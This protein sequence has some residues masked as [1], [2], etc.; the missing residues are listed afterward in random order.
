MLAPSNRPL[1]F[2]YRTMSA[3]WRQR[4][5]VRDQRSGVSTDLRPLT[6]D[7]CGPAG[8]ARLSTLVALCALLLVV[9]ALPPALRSSA[10]ADSSP[11]TH[12]SSLGWLSDHVWLHSPTL[13]SSPSALSAL[14]FT[15]LRAAEPVAVVIPLTGGGSITSFGSALTENFDG[16]SST[17]ATGVAWTD[18]STISG[19]YASQ[20]AYNVSTGSSTTGA[21]YS[22]GVAGTNA[23]TDRALGALASGGTGT[24]YYGFRLTNATG[25]SVGGLSISYK[26]EQWRNSAAAAQTTNFQYQ[27]ANAG[28]ITAINTPTTGWTTF[29]PLSFT[30]P[31]TGGSAGLLDGNAAA[32]RTAKSATLTFGTPVANGQEIWIRWQ[33]NDDTGNDHGLGIDDLS[34]TA[35]AAAEPTT[36]ATNVVFSNIT[37]TSMTVGWTNGNGANRI[38]LAKEGSAVNSDPVDGTTYTANAAFGGGTQIG[39]GNYVIFAGSGNSVDVTGLTGGKTYYFAV[40]EFNGSS[41]GENYLTTSPATGNQTTDLVF[42]GDGNLPAGTYRNVTLNCTTFTNVTLTGDVTITGTFTLNNCSNLY[43]NNHVLSGAGSFVMN[44]GTWLH[45]S[46]ANGITSGT[47]LSGN[48]QVTGG[49]TFPTTGNYDYD[50]GTNQVVGDGLPSPVNDLLISKNGGANN[51]A[52]TGNS[53]QV[54]TTLLEI[55]Q[56]VYS[57]HSTYTDV[58]IDSGGTLTLAG[59]S[60]VSGNWTNNG[61][62]NN[63]GFKITFNGAANQLISGSTSTA[64]ATLAISNTGV[65]GSNTVSLAQNISDT[66]LNITSGVFDQGASFNVAS[67]TV[68]VSAGATWNDV[69]SGGVALSGNVANA[70]TI[71][72]NG[73]TTACG[74]ADSIAITSTGGQRAWTGTGT[75]NMTDVTVSNQGATPPPLITVH[76]GTDAGSNGLNWVFLGCTANSYTWTGASGPA[77]TDWTVPTNWSP[78][79]ATPDPG[80]VLTFDNN[81]SP[82]VTNIPTQTISRLRIIG[83]TSPQF[84]AGANGNILTIN[85]GA[86]V[87]GFDVFGLSVTGSNAL[88]IKLGSGTLGTVTNFM[89]V[90]GGAHKVISNDAGGI[91]FPNNSI[92]STQAG[93]SDFPFGD[94]DPGSGAAGSVI[95]QSGATYIHNA[96]SSPFGGNTASV[97]TFQTGS[98]AQ[99]LTG[100][101]FDACGRTYADLLIGSNSVAVTASQTGSCASQN[102]QFDNLTVNN[103]AGD[104]SLSYTGTGTIT[105]RGNISSTGAGTGLADVTLTPGA[106]GILI[107]GGGTQTFSHTNTK[108]LN[109]DGN[110]NIAS[111]TTLT[112][113]RILVLGMINSNSKTVTVASGATLNAG[114][115]GYVVGSLRR[116]FTGAGSKAFEVGALNGYSPVDMTAAAGGTFPAVFTVNSS[117]AK[118]PHIH[119][120][121]GNALKRYW[122]L[123]EDSGSITADLV[124]HYLDPAD[125]PTNISPAFTDA[126][127]I[128]F[129]YDGSFS[130]PSAT[131]NTAANTAT[132]T[133]VS[134]FS[135][136]T[137]ADPSAVTPGTLTF[138]GAP[139]ST[140]EGNSSSHDVT[141][142]VSRT[143]GTDGA[144]DVSYTTSDGTAQLAD[145]DYVLASGVLHWND[146]ETGN[147]SFTITVNGD[148]T[149][150]ADE[151]VN[152]TLSPPTDLATITPPNPTTLTILNDDAPPASLVVNTTDDNDFGACF[153]SPGHC[154]LREA[155]NAANF[156]V[157]TST[158]TFAAAANGTITLT[159]ALPNLAN[160]LTINGNGAANTVISGNDLF[161]PFTVSSSADV[162]ITGVTVTHGKGTSGGAI[163]NDGTLTVTNSILSSNMVTVGDGGGIFNDIGATLTVTNCTISGNSAGSGGGGIDNDG[164]LM[165]MGSTISGN[166]ADNGGGLR[167]VGP[168]FVTNCTI[169]GN[170]AF[171]NGGGIHNFG[172]T[173]R[174]TNST[175]TNNFADSADNGGLGGGIFNESGVTV[176]LRNTI[177]ARNFNGASPG[178]N[179]DDLNGD[180]VDTANCFNNL[181][182]TGG[183]GGLTNTNGNQ[184]DVADPMLGPLQNN[185]GLTFTHA[186]LSGSTAIDAGD[187]CVADATHCSDPNIT[188]LTTDQ[189]GAGFPR[190]VDGDLNGTAAVDIGAYEFNQTQTGATFVVNSTN[191]PGDGVCD[192]AECTLREAI[193]AAN[194]NADANIIT[195]DIPATDLGHYY[196][197]DDGSGTPNGHV[198]PANVTTTTASVD[199]SIPDIDPDW[200][201]SWWSIRPTTTALP[202]I[203]QQVTINGYSQPGASPNTQ[204]ATDD[205]VI[206]IELNGVNAGANAHGLAANSVSTLQGL[207]INHF[208]G[209]GIGLLLGSSSGG[210]STVSGNFIGTDVSGTL[211]AANGLAGLFITH[212]TGQQVGCTV[213]E[214][215]NII[216]GN[217]GEGVSILTAG[218]NFVQGNFIGVAANGTS[219]L[220]N[221]G[222]GIEIYTGGSNNTIGAITNVLGTQQ[223]RPE[224]GGAS[225]CQRSRTGSPASR[226]NSKPNMVARVAPTQALS[227]ANVIAGNGEDGV[228]VSSAGDTGNLI[229]QN[230]IFS[231]GSGPNGGLGI[232]LVGPSDPPNGVTL[233]D[234]QGH[235]GPNNL[236]NFPVITIATVGTTTVS[237]TLVSNPTRSFTIEIFVNSSC[238]T[239]SGYGEGQ[240]YF[241]SAATSE[242]A[243]GQYTWQA[244]VPMMIT[245][246][247]VFT[248]TATDLT[249]N[250]T[251]EFSQCRTS[252]SNTNPTIAALPVSQ[253]EGS[254]ASSNVHIADVNDVESGPGGVTVTVNGAPS[255]TV[256]GVTVSGITNTGGTVTATVVAACGGTNATFTLTA[257]DG[258][259]GTATAMLNVTVSANTAPTLTYAP[260]YTVTQGNSLSPATGPSDNGSVASIVVQSAGMFTGKL[261]V[262]PV[263]AVVSVSNTAPAGTDNVTIRATDNCGTFTDATFA[264]T[265]NAASCTAPPSGMVAWWPGDGN[266]DD[267]TGNGNNGTLEGN[268]T[269]G[270]GK[271]EQAFDLNGTTGT[272]V[273]FTAN[274]IPVGSGPR[275]V[276]MWVK[277]RNAA[278]D[279]E[280]L[281]YGTGATRRAFGIDVDDTDGNGNVGLQLFTFGDDIQLNSGVPLNQWM[282]IAATYDGNLTINV[283]VNGELKATLPLGAPL[284]TASSNV[285]LGHFSP[286]GYF[287]GL[288]DEV[289]VFNRE[290]SQTEIRAIYNASF[291]GKCRTCTTAPPNMVSWYSAENNANDIFGTNNGTMYGGVS[292]VP[293]KLGQAFSF[294]GVSGTR[295][296]ILRQVQDD[297]TI[298]FWLNSTQN[299]FDGSNQWHSAAGLVDGEVPGVVNDFGVS[300]G[301]GKVLFGVGNVNGNDLTIRSGFVADGT[302]HHI[303][304]TRVKSS[305]A[306]ALYIDGVQVA[307]DTGG[308]QSL[309]DPTYLR[310][311]GVPSTTHFFAG[312]LDEVEIFNRA[313]SQTEIAA[314]ADAGSAGKCHT[315]TIQFSS[316]TYQVTEGSGNATITVTRAGTHDTLAHVNYATS[317]GTATAGVDYTETSSTLDFAVGEVSKTFDVP[318]LQ[319]NSFAHDQTVNLT[320]S[321]V[322]GT[323]AS[324]GTPNP[325]LLTIHDTDDQAP[326]FSITQSV[327]HNEGNTGTTDF[328]FTVT[329]TGTTQVPATVDFATAAGLTNPATG[330]VSCGAGID[331]QSQNNTLN[332]AANQTTQTITVKVCGD[333]TYEANEKFTVV[334]SNPTEATVSPTLGTGTGTIVNDDAAPTLSINNLAL[335]EGNSGPTDFAFTVTK[336]GNAT[337]LPTTV[338]FATV[339]GL[340][341]GSNTGATGGVSCGAGID[342]ESQSGMLTFQPNDTTMTI[343]V[344]VCGDP[345]YENN[346]LFFVNLSGPVDGS[347]I[348]N[349]GTGTIKNDDPIPTISIDNVT[350]NEGD[351]GTTDFVFHITKTNPTELPI[352]VHAKTI[353]H[354]SGQ[355]SAPSDFTAIADQ[356]FTFPASSTT[357]TQTLTV[358]VNGDT[359]Y[360]HD[361]LFFVNVFN[362]TNASVIESNGTGTIVN[363]D[364]KPTLSITSAVMHPEGNGPGTTD[365]TFTITKT[366]STEVNAT[367][368]VDTADGT[369]TAPSDYTA[370]TNQTVTFLPGETTKQVTVLVKADTRPEGDETFLV[371][372][373]NPVDCAITAGQGQGTGTIQNDD[374]CPTVFTVNNNGD[375]DDVDPGDGLCATSGGQ[376]TLRAA[377]EEAN[378][379]TACGTIDINFSIGSATITL[380]NGQLTV[381]H[382]VNVN[383][384]TLSSIV[385]SGNNA[386]RALWVNPGKTVTISNL[387]LSGGNGSGSS[388]GAILNNGGTITLTNSTVSGN[389]VSSG[390][391][392]GGIE[393]SGTLTLTN[394][395]VSGNTAPY[396]GGGIDNG[397]ASSVALTNSTVTGNTAQYGG[398]IANGGTVS[399][400]NTIIAGNS[401]SVSGPDISGSF[402]S[403]GNNLIGKSDGGSG[404]LNGSNGDQV[405]TIASPIDPLLGA[406]MNNGGPTF[407]HGLLYNSPAVDAGNDCVFTVTHCSDANIPQL[408]LDQRGL[409]RQANGD[410]IAGAHVDIGAYERQASESRPVPS[411]SNVH[412][413]LNDVRL[414]F[415]TVSGTRRDDGAAN[416]LQPAT[417]NNAV[418]ITVIPVPGDAPPTSFAAFDVTPTSAFYATPVDVCFYLPSITPKATFDKLKV[419]HRESGV[420]TDHGTYVN[421]A[422][423]IACTEVTSFSDF[424][425]GYGAVPSVA[426]GTIDGMITDSSGAPLAGTTINLSGTQA[427]EAI[428]DSS[429]NYSFEGV[430]TN[431]FYSVTPSRANY[432]FNPANRSFSALGVH[433][434]ASFTA[435]PN[436]DHANAIDTTEFF[437]RQQY[438]DFLGREPDPPGFNGWVNTIRDCAPGDT[439]CDRIHVSEA[440]FRSAEFQERGYFVYRFYASAFGR[441]PDYGEFTPDLRRVSGFLTNDQLEAAKTAF[442]NDFMARSAFAAQ[443]NSLSN[444]AYVDALINTAAVNLS[445]RPALLDGLNS[446]TLTRAQVLRQITESGEVYQK[447][448]NQAFVVMEYFGYLR[449]DPD[450]LY[451]NWIQVLDANAADSR[452]MVNGFVNSTEY[453]NR[454]AQ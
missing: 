329:K 394:S 150:E 224:G 367:V 282:H 345:N 232:N 432:T 5:E 254:L 139:Y 428:T 125:I 230:S 27:V 178:I 368:Q 420:L 407:T 446:G 44:A 104:S 299:A 396:A 88:I 374:P 151:T 243:P 411:G 222:N 17:V 228:R 100:S 161:K 153:P 233:N 289:E 339:D 336:S 257:D 208:T 252:S 48:I 416:T 325:A 270:A 221:G 170:S 312:Q 441:K 438:L 425:I 250:D 422:S 264:L 164:T 225:G 137:L 86:S 364:P 42:S 199:T 131:V 331:Y 84:S 198:T 290:L 433:T 404:F 320:L 287:D 117:A 18:N 253:Q 165:L 263:T 216:S 337:E 93:F 140:P 56:G 72:F 370:I 238:D 341:N 352:T 437:V 322:T 33:D 133:G 149:Y 327:S 49:R 274:N 166:S 321:A 435:S 242:G 307:T 369:A 426:N 176:T 443:Y 240:S 55:I 392:G 77:P 440:F 168:M 378:A 113:S 135:D 180:N 112:L 330:G 196:Y 278:H 366:G 358:L 12:N 203:T 409:S 304:A 344:N 197:K 347:I 144:L 361:E 211:A 311:G 52:V 2:I 401:A 67:G 414:A 283:Y 292:F 314:I 116:T 143:G 19:S 294:D 23:V 218:G 182:G 134:S 192:D 302:W 406:L 408:A 190:K 162:T 301:E 391:R 141:I 96:G 213:A 273:S 64:F 450:A 395:T 184:V 108:P 16:L 82:T 61:T 78:A 212:S 193:N 375:A 109:F 45:V 183:S 237:G 87:T 105:I 122:T 381:D 187:D 25:S 60:T 159:S 171:N 334:L 99:Y 136:W 191:D 363:D 175:I 80:D 119:V 403:Q 300:L 244:T 360:E 234:S 288:I 246:G 174:I 11:I 205:A 85:A 305:G 434:E 50:G 69:G 402:T 145:N 62:F 357:D 281:F 43:T 26:G 35:I 405:G 142:T 53:G 419:F 258:T 328:V 231:N 439:S 121:T 365:F 9:C 291:A 39:S 63:A 188:Q 296:E 155:I 400:R 417:V 59:D 89:S 342:Y 356:T 22:Y 340:H 412:V 319:D 179:A 40:Y 239:P 259:G 118:E 123:S 448:Y 76:D 36:P 147:K 362:A 306:I 373:S 8:R 34:I 260:S 103:T 235:N 249:T 293:G 54:V 146:G 92:F 388:G 313:L 154:S 38:V 272:D 376:C 51:N 452:H 129:K 267:V 284:D 227:G 229:S 338:N 126:N 436:G 20:T 127:Y 343:H 71:T 280:I 32:N 214:E 111:G 13:S 335:N 1:S 210:F 157:D 194:A 248:A 152:I 79:R 37:S 413:D 410:L 451:T 383:G 265:V 110:V 427:R 186:L 124:F 173:V 81:S 346:E 423:K 430:E 181:I 285:V 223:T 83:T 185:G 415:P 315:S 24:V 7:L 201:H 393:N 418:S 177:V 379:L 41:G 397:G 326:V 219:L 445:N 158:I 200:P 424:V 421:F 385:I 384:P 323:G 163:R 241:A 215:R 333:T 268:A 355:A 14:L 236:Q 6:S 195:F 204:D 255:A 271:V 377:I 351:A 349:P 354:P 390:Y 148:T 382:N 102:F 21:M 308:T 454:F 115:S 106:G 317:A 28:T 275:T 444:S 156:N 132:I 256:S 70:G 47:T 130:A 359:M 261:S 75:F 172:G 107:N 371:N 10:A 449:R 160:A 74:E 3:L 266:A 73:G 324:L 318:I 398:G 372:L 387:T 207:A 245:T 31:V 286:A 98:S 66:A 386:S 120:A 206:R 447:Y 169:S 4:A 429:G 279:H 262:D 310:L 399:V 389:S 95:F 101:G 29:S 94:G 277:V 30:S 453:R 431:G 91:T 46:D 57:S 97:A 380:T 217:T 350:H 251:S 348:Q 332:F 189:R 247:Q 128:L 138:V 68:N 202:A 303:A 15:P 297:F 353:N 167:T 295:V 65:G 114:S 442:V 209:N 269:F 220:G 316:A 90:A 309:S 276:D 58:Q 298:D 226:Q